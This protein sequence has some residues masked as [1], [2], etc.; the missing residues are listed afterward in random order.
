MN[1]ANTKHIIIGCGAQCKYALDIFSRTG[2]A[3]E[4]ILD[5]IGGKTGGQ[6]NGLPISRLDRAEILTFL[7]FLAELDGNIPRALECF[8]NTLAIFPDRAYIKER[9]AVLE[10]GENPEVTARNLLER[11]TRQSVHDACKDHDG[12]HDHDA[13]HDHGDDHGDHTTRSMP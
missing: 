10:A 5:P 8:K 9:V 4:A 3:V 11:L 12:D 2:A 7:G 1:Q 13:D 6:L